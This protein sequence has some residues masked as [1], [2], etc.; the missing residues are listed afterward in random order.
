MALGRVRRPFLKFFIYSA[1]S[2]TSTSSCPIPVFA[3]PQKNWA[4]ITITDP[5]SLLSDI[6]TDFTL[7]TNHHRHDLHFAVVSDLSDVLSALSPR[8]R[9]FHVN[10]DDP[11][12]LFD[13]FARL[14]RGERLTFHRSERRFYQSVAGT[15]DIRGGLPTW[16][17]VL[18]DRS[19]PRLFHDPDG[20]DQGD[21]EPIDDD[22]EDDE[23]WPG[24]MPPAFDLVVQPQSLQSVLQH[25]TTTL[26]VSND[27]QR[28]KEYSV[29]R[30]CLGASGVL[31]R[32]LQEHPESREIA[33]ECDDNR[34]LPTL[35]DLFQFAPV[36]VT[37]GN[38][39]ELHELAEFLEIPALLDVTT[40]FLDQRTQAQEKTDIGSTFSRILDLE[41]ALLGVAEQT[42]DSTVESVAENGW[43]ESDDDIKE[44]LAVVFAIAEGRPDKMP[45]LA[46]F[47][48]AVSQK[49]R[50]DVLKRIVESRV[51]H[52][53]NGPF[54]FHLLQESLLDISTIVHFYRNKCITAVGIRVNQNVRQ[55]PKTGITGFVIWLL[56]ELSDTFPLVLDWLYQERPDVIEELRDLEKDDWKLYKEY[57]LNGYNPNQF[58]IAIRQD[59]VNALQAHLEQIDFD[60]DFVVPQSIFDGAWPMPLI[61]YS[62]LWGR[63][64]AFDSCF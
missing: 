16:M 62:V 45:V 11:D 43:L 44:L 49:G 40:K 1:R 32:L 61:G 34:E 2:Q 3:P 39:D 55:D 23:E 64:I 35:A 4:A 21:G 12:N 48:K 42:I 50:A 13:K 53:R 54:A 9:E 25:S 7:V 52:D 31:L 27:G 10:L 20:F 63:S 51:I 18:G 37:H 56:P 41:V 22:E 8:P 19:G 47:L 46:R 33:I 58:A 29:S 59:N 24:R 38:V 36:E 57:R 28:P 6:P 5:A 26:I 30:Y 14:F 15:L 17:T 60:Y